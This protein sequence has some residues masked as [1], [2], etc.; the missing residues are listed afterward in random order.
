MTAPH[1]GS[2]PPRPRCAHC[3]DVIGAY[4]PMIVCGRN[5]EPRET[6]LTAE[7]WA[8]ETDLPRFHR[9]CFQLARDCT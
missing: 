9:V 2:A 3:L 4:E 5:S 6:S 8:Y 1:D 7:P